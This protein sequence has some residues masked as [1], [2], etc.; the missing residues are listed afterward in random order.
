MDKVYFEIED[1]EAIK[2]TPLLH[3]DI[4]ACPECGQKP[5]YNYNICPFCG[6]KIVK[7]QE[8]EDE[9]DGRYGI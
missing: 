5:Y 3:Q 4:Y 2:Y 7:P 8:S 1:N 9:D 6:A